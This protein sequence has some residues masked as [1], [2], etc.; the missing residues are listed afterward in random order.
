MKDRGR[1]LVRRLLSAG[2]AVLTVHEGVAG[3]RIVLDHIGSFA[4]RLQMQD[5]SVPIAKQWSGVAW[6]VLAA[7]LTLLT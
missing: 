4:G 2:F 1:G 5:Q 7:G 3:P 6:I